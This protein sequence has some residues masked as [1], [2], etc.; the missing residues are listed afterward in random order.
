MKAL[1]TGCI[2]FFAFI[3]LISNAIAQNA[4]NYTVTTPGRPSTFINQ[5][6][7]GGGYTMTTPGQPATF[8]NPNPVGGGYTINTPGRPQTYVNPGEN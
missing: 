7:V 2:G 3:A 8:I 4:Q 1:K 6:P 5:D